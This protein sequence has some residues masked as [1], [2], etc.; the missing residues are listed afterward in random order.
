MPQPGPLE[1]MGRV[2]FPPFAHEELTLR[3]RQ[4]VGTGALPPAWHR[5]PFPAPGCR[6]TSVPEA[7]IVVSK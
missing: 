3:T 7:L 4:L 2:S 6:L 5:C 1:V